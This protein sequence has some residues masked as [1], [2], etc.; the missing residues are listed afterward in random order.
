VPISDKVAKRLGLATDAS[1]DDVLAKLDELA[2]TDDKPEG[3]KPDEGDKPE[4][5]AQ[6][7][8]PGAPAGTPP[9]SQPDSGEV[10]QL[11]AAAAKL[12]LVVTLPDELAQLK[13]GAAAGA[14][15]EEARLSAERESYVDK[16]VDA[17]K[18][19]P[20][21]KAKV[22]ALMALDDK[23]TRAAIDALPAEAALPITE[24]GHS[25]ES[26]G[27]ELS[28]DPIFSEWVDS[29]KASHR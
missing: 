27:P 26:V 12:G 20:V 25:T 8:T 21:N 10:S 11:T 15:A 24:L 18:I 23:G 17:G 16:A 19:L 6:P 28:A 22:L 9:A 4:T 5:P 2:K 1:D 29:L 3:D 13:A 14:R 7:E